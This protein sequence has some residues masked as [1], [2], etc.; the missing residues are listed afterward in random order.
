MN[1]V[2][3]RVVV[4]DP[5]GQVLQVVGD[6]PAD[7]S[8]MISGWRDATPSEQRARVALG[9]AHRECAASQAAHP[10]R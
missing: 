4:M 2:A 7:E 10:R 9:C 1:T 8:V 3:H 6:A 5:S